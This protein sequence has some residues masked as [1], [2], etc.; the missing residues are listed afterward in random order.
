MTPAKDRLR[1][2]TLEMLLTLP[3]NSV[4]E[5]SIQFHKG[6][7]RWTEHPPDAHHGFYIRYIY[8]LQT[9]ISFLTLTLQVT[10]PWKTVSVRKVPVFR[11]MWRHLLL[12]SP[13]LAQFSD[14]LII[15]GNSSGTAD[16]SESSMSIFVFYRKNSQHSS[17]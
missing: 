3:A 13:V 4:T 2:Y 8:S 6:F 15:V 7:L 10:T 5:L 9:S 1:P 14:W 16:S 11:E 12:R 17:Y